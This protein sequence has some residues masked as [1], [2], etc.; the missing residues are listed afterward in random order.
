MTCQKKK[1]ECDSLY[2]SVGLHIKLTQNRK[3]LHFPEP[4]KGTTHRY[5]LW[6]LHGSTGILTGWLRSAIGIFVRELEAPDFTLGPSTL[7]QDLCPTVFDNI[8]CNVL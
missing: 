3:H 4:H 2:L 7:L 6:I 5:Y 1:T 8:R